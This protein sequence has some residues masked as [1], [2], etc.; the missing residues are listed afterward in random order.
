MTI[1]GLGNSSMYSLNDILASGTS[2]VAS[3]DGDVSTGFSNDMTIAQ[4]RDQVDKMALSGELTSSQQ[5][6]LIV[7]GFQDVNAND[8]SY[9]PAAQTGYTRQTTGTFDPSTI[10]QSMGAFAASQGNT[11]SAASYDGLAS[12]FSQT[13]SV[14]AVNVTA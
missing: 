5:M 11:S 13:E 6:H 7:A 10:L 12:L 8:P 9:Q 3:A 4:I 2:S 1:S 14:S